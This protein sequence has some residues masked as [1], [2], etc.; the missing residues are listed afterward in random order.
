MT[1]ALYAH[2]NN[3]RKKRERECMLKKAYILK[4]CNLVLE[5]LPSNTHGPG[6]DPQNCKKKFF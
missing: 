4:E 6:L 1:Q 5:H 2:M 3:K